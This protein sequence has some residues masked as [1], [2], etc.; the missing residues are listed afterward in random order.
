MF[1]KLPIIPREPLLNPSHGSKASSCV[2]PSKRGNEGVGEGDYGLGQSWR[3]VFLLWA[4]LQ[5]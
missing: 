2:L 4:I 5:T 3:E 1:G